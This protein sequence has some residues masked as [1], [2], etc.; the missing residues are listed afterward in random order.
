MASPIAHSFA[1]LWTFFYLRA[2]SKAQTMAQWR[3][4]VPRLGLLIMLANA[5]DLDFLITPGFPNNGL[6]RGFTHSLIVAI[7]IALSLSCVWRITPGFW[8][9][10]SLYFTAYGSH[11]L[12]DLFTGTKIGWTN[13]G[14]GLQ[15]FWPWAEKISSPLTL[16]IGVHHKD[17]AA[18]FSVANIWSC[19]YE[20]L[21]CGAI[22][23]VVLVLWKRKQRSRTS[24]RTS[25][26]SANILPTRQHQE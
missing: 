19:T 13:S 11:L 15:L 25:Q 21:V 24:P 4:Y 14:S 1:G 20:L 6:H 26:A 9:S 5:P 16:I 10:A 7:L 22:T 12:I 3:Y 8:R 2:R 17:M 18:L 23:L